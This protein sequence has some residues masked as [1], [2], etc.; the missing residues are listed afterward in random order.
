MSTRYVIVAQFD[1]NKHNPTVYG[2][3]SSFD[4]AK[5]QADQWQRRVAR[6]DPHSETLISVVPMDG[7]TARLFERDFRE[8]TGRD[9]AR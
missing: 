8:R 6:T 9:L 4:A 5:M 7:K 2:T 1:G 3:W